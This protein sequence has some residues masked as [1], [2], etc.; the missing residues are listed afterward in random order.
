MTTLPKVSIIT[1]CLNSSKYL[2][3]A[4]RSVIGQTYKNTEYIIIDGES[5][6]GT[7]EIL[8]KYSD[9]INK[10]IIEKDKGV[11]DAMNKGIGMASGEIIYFLNSDDKLHNSNTVENAVSFFIK[12]KDAN[13]I[14]GNI[15]VFNPAD[16]FSYIERYPH[17]I[18]KW[19]FIAKTIAQPGSFFKT[20]C[21]KKCGYF[22][23]NYKFAADHDW[24]LKA[25]FLKKLK[26][27]HIEDC[28]S[29]F[30]LGGLSNNRKYARD[31]FL[32]R[33]AIEK[34]Y[35]NSFELLCADFMHAIK[36]FLGKKTMSFLHRTRVGVLNRK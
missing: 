19:L 27:V 9:N 1:V 24:Y 29:V 12:N 7:H 13:F 2:E 34:K 26:A 30:R 16:N 18:T 20:N 15:E 21:F 22:D 25:I 10:V 23:I 4:I 3:D 31:Y 14:Y 11:F 17:K 36:M 6:D 33:K 5:A 32:E 8:H 28:I 35:L